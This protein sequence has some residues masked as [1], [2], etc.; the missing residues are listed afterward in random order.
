[1]L[2]L[3]LAELALELG[4]PLVDPANDD[5]YPESMTCDPVSVAA[6]ETY[7]KKLVEA[8]ASMIGESEHEHRMRGKQGFETA[9]RVWIEEQLGKLATDPLSSTSTEHDTIESK[10]TADTYLPFQDL[11]T[12][13]RATE[14]AEPLAAQLRAGIADEFGWPAYEQAL[15]TL[16]G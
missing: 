6:H 12:R 2:N 13:L 5:F 3:D 8:V 7:G 4:I 14:L 10:T 9:R 16:D 15:A 1:D 11:W